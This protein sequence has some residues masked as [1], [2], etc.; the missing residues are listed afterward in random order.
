MLR[1]QIISLAIACTFIP[2]F[3]QQETTVDVLTMP[4]F[5]PF[6]WEDLSTGE[7]TGFD[8]ELIREIGKLAGFAPNIKTIDFN[9]IVPALQAKSAD[10]AIASIFATPQRGEIVD[11]STPYYKSGIKLLVSANNDDINTIEDLPGK[12]LA[13]LTGSG[14]YDFAE[15]NAPEA[16]NIP[17][18]SASDLYLALMGNSVD[19]VLHDSP[20]IAYFEKTKGNGKVKTVGPLYDGVD[21]AIAFP[22]GSKWVTPVNEAL[23]TLHDNGTYDKLY[24][25]YFGSTDQ[26]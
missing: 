1:R 12:R 9:G 20:N 6:E 25:Q 16:E 3:A 19:A 11:F 14:A 22:K 26:K 18:P 21:V 2:A 15:K 10:M 7:M 5:P 24:A 8:I 23:Q 4:T 13:T 17:Y